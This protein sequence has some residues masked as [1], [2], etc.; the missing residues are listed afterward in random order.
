MD[1][2]A[3]GSIDKNPYEWNVVLS[4]RYNGQ[5]QAIGNAW[6]DFTVNGVS[7]KLDLK[8]ILVKRTL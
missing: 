7:K 5:G 1:L 3:C 6:T 8:N 2:T 4:G